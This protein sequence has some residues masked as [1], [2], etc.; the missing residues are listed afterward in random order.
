VRVLIFGG[1]RFLGR[2]LVEEL[3]VRHHDVTLFNRGKSNPEIFP[4]VPRIIG[5]R[6]KY[7][8]LEPLRGRRFDAVI[9]TSAYLPRDADAATRATRSIADRYVFTSSVSVYDLSHAHPDEASPTLR[10]S[11]GVDSAVYDD[12]WYGQL[13]A[14]CEER[15]IESFASD[16]SLIVRPGLIVGPH[17]PTDRFTYWPWRAAR[18]GEF[19][20]PVGPATPTQFIDARDLARWMVAMVERGTTGVFN[21]SSAAGA[22][23]FGRLLNACRQAGAA[24]ATP[25]WCSE[26]FLEANG[27]EAW[28]DLPVWISSRLAL[29]GMLSINVA[30]AIG[31]GLSFRSIHETVGDTLAWAQSR[32]DR[33]WKA[34]LTQERE[35]ALLAAIHQ[36]L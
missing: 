30:K 16:R 13:K 33:A 14:L 9:D 1:T 20:A 35:A 23:D 26:R 8:E 28:T 3:L 29:P 7:N 19:I 25:V 12:R 11:N 31:E 24:D 5:D 36:E 32:P 15:V 21:A 4:N 17:D 22:I 2:H 10:L 27:V 18:G 6:S 34:G